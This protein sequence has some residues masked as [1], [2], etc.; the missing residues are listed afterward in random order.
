[1]AHYHA[2]FGIASERGVT[3]YR[4]KTE[5][6]EQR[7]KPFNSI[8][9][10][11][12]YLILPFCVILV[13]GIILLLF[14]AAAKLLYLFGNITSLSD[15]ALLIGLFSIIDLALL[16]NILLLIA[17]SGY[18]SF[19]SRLNE[20]AEGIIGLDALD[21][22]TLAKVKLKLLGSMIVISAIGLLSTFLSMA[23]DEGF[24]Q[25]A[26]LQIA[27]H[28]VLSLSAVLLAVSDRLDKK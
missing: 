16:A 26:Y 11:A 23:S 13:L 2:V 4:V 12:R 5:A 28:I 8:I 6:W 19:I 10:K 22:L 7:V 25:T 3:A 18:D 24:N 1:M 17:L 27:I 21:G 20:T 9:L 15:T 14:Q